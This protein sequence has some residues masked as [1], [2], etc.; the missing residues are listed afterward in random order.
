MDFDKM[1]NATQAMIKQKKIELIAKRVIDLQR[2][3]KIKPSA[4]NPIL[5]NH[6]EPQLFPRK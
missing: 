2:R 6:P 5:L 1:F 3:A 4:M